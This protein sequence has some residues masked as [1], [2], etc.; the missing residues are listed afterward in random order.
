[1]TLPRPRRHTFLLAIFALAGLALAVFAGRALIAQVSGDRG[2]AAVASSSDIDVGG[3]DVDVTA[4]T[5]QDARQQGW[6]LAIQKAWK[7]L[8]GPALP[9]SQVESLVSAVVIQREELGPHRYIARLGISF[10]HARAGAFLGKGGI[11]PRSAPLLLIPVTFSA[12][13]ET[14]YEVRNPWQRAWAEYQPGGS[15]IDYVRPSGANGDSLLLTAGQITR[16]S[17]TWWRGVLDQFG[18]TDVLMALAD[19]RYRWP[20]GPIDG[21]FT[22]RYGPDNTYLGSFKMT[23][24]GPSELQDMLGKAVERFNTIYEQALT[25]GK[26]KPDPTLN[27]GAPQID[28]AIQRLINLGRAAQAMDQASDAAVAAGAVLPGDATAASTPAP[29]AVVS[30]YVVQFA[31][32]N[33]GAVDATIAAVRAT[34]GVRGAVTSSLAIGGTSVMSVSYG[35]SLS[36][37]AGALRSRGFSVREGG[38]ALAIS[39]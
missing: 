15:R 2:I 18:A 13:T 35:G 5:A 12:G 27:F 19:L 23:A 29:V 3:I 39:R 25:D 38:N 9:E 17:R 20:G 11:G 7:K 21:T 36:E 31:T 30:R 24:Q 37:L 28:P 4:K 1:M 10:D 6:K 22:A 32:P 26:L 16:R 33:A 8:N 14:V 34:P